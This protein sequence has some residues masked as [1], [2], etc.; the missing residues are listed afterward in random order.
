MGTSASGIVWRERFDYRERWEEDHNEATRVFD[1]LWG[2]RSTFIQDMLGYAENP[3]T[4]YVHRV[5]PE[6]HPEYQWMFAMKAETLNGIGVPL[7]DTS[8][9][10][11]I[12]FKQRDNAGTVSETSSD[13]YAH[14]A[15]HYYAPDFD[16][17]DDDAVKRLEGLAYAP[18]GELNRYVS[19]YENYAGENL[20]VA[21]GMFLFSTDNQPI[22]EPPPKIFVNK[23]L[24]YVWHW[25]PTVPEDTIQ[26]TLGKVNIYPFDG[27]RKDMTGAYVEKYP[28]ETLLFIGVDRKRIISPLGNVLYQLA[29]KFLFRGGKDQDGNQLTHNKIFRASTN[30]FE[31]VK[32]KNKPTESIYDTAN[33]NLLFELP[34]P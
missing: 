1:V 22:P 9:D 28:A 24:T 20:E 17:V 12:V 5:I 32:N 19:R 8:T 15:I 29:Y 21:G 2:D 30:R 10:D 4:T 13:G 7:A 25:V 16:I 14:V 31:G 3:G 23:E 26:N 11:M 33:F 18:A 27:K 6:S 34:P